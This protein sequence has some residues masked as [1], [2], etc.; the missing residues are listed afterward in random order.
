MG[1][2]MLSLYREIAQA[3]ASM[4]ECARRGDWDA[5]VQAE[6][7]CRTLIDELR[8]LGNLELSRAELDEKHNIIR[9]LLADDAEIRD[10]AQPWMKR[11]QTMLTSS[12]NEQRL[13]AMYGGSR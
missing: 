11:L 13:G 12:Q 2:A 5:L 8:A 3:S 6:G 7:R 1:D 9:K 10:L 4:L